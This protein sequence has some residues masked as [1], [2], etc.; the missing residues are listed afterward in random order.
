MRTIY[1]NKVRGLV[2]SFLPLYL[3]T[4]LPLL[5]SCDY[6]EEADRLIAVDD[7]HTD[8]PIDTLKTAIKNVLLE[9]FTGQRCSN[10]PTGTEVI[11]QLQEIY[12]ERLIAVGIHGGPL[13]FKGTATVLGLATDVGD[14]YYSHW[15]LEYQPVGLVDRHGAVNYTEWAKAVRDEMALTSDVKMEVQAIFDGSKIDITVM[16]EAYNDYTG[17]LQVWLLEDGITAIQTMPDGTNNRNY[18]HNHV[19]RTPVNGDWGKAITIGKGEQDLQNYQQA[20]DEAWNAANLSVVA[21]VYND[22]GVM[23]VT[24]GKVIMNNDN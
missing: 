5:M 1:L 21:F 17:M 14:E 23:Q 16:E 13:G 6:I 2:K 24:K 4:F 10:C 9:D 3:F 7:A 18:V 22:R 12:G 20:V 11:E 19:L 8:T 15:Q